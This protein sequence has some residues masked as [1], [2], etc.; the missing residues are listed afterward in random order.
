MGTVL[1]RQLGTWGRFRCGKSFDSGE[2]EPSPCGL[3][4]I[5]DNINVLYVIKQK[6]K[7]DEV[8]VII[9]CIMIIPIND[10][11]IQNPKG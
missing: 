3:G 1:M 2:R 4:L 10:S 6:P 5:C 11:M 8:S 9:G 7:A